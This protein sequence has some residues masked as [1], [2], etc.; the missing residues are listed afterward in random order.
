[1]AS[2]IKQI[3]AA[4]KTAGVPSRLRVGQQLIEALP[5]PGNL[6]VEQPERQ[7][8]TQAF[9]LGEQ[10][11]QTVDQPLI[12]GDIQRHRRVGDDQRPV[13][14]RQQVV[15]GEDERRGAECR[16]I[17]TAQRCR[18]RQTGIE[19]ATGL[20]A[21]GQIGGI[22][23]RRQRNSAVTVGQT[24]VERQ[25]CAC[26]QIHRAIVDHHRRRGRAEHLRR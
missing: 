16:K 18:Q 20:R 15:G 11:H 5:Q 24:P 22:A 23:D 4:T 13:L 10:I 1:M 8:L 19:R 21:N 12:D 25:A 2:G 26:T 3:E 17:E 7:V 9:H 6:G 14:I